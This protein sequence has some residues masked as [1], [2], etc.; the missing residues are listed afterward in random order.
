MG[1][2]PKLLPTLVIVLCVLS[3]VVYLTGKDYR[4]AAYWAACAVLYI[5][6]TY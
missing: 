3:A 1:I 4:H 6:V 5:A 2:N